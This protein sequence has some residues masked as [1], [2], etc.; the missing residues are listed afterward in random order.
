MKKEVV[1]RTEIGEK[2]EIT[3]RA[4]VKEREK[5]R[6]SDGDRNERWREKEKERIEM[7]IINREKKVKGVSRTEEGKKNEV[8]KRT[9]VKEG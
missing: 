6:V 5:E 3:K 8:T 9:R 4:R 1:G 2:N 7:E